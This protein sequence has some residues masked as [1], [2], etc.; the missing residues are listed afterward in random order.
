[1]SGFLEPPSLVEAEMVPG[2][3]NKLLIQAEPIELFKNIRSDFGKSAVAR[4]A[5]HFVDT[6]VGV[7]E[8]DQRLFNLFQS[9]LFFLETSATSNSSLVEGFVFQAVRLLGF[10]PELHVCVSGGETLQ[11][12]QPLFFDVALGGMLCPIC[13]VQKKSLQMVGAFI[14]VE[15]LE[16]LQKLLGASN[17]NEINCLILEPLTRDIVYQFS[18][19][20]LAKKIP[21][22]VTW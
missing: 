7:G 22:L 12:Q 18:E 3:E 16:Q 14:T 15:V 2:K 20:H 17:W 13:Y 1:L 19:Y 9:W 21:R 10:E 6:Q 5:V 4:Y 8:R 11:L